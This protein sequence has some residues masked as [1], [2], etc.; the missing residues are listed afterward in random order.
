MILRLNVNQFA[1]I[2]DD[3]FYDLAYNV[4]RCCQNK[5]DVEK[6]F[7]IGWIIYNLRFSNMNIVLIILAAKS[8]NL[9]AKSWFVLKKLAARLQRILKAIKIT[10]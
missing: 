9:V 10:N 2:F 5:K 3:E 7:D 6:K 1:A 8:L 4:S